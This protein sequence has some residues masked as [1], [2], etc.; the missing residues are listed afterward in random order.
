MNTTEAHERLHNDMNSALSEIVFAL[1]KA[2]LSPCDALRIANKA[3]NRC[4]II[5]DDIMSLY[6]LRPLSEYH[7]DF[8]SVL[9]WSLPICEPPWVGVPDCSSW[10]GY[11]THWSPLPDCNRMVANDGTKVEL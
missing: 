10:P 9:W 2:G 11:H 3:T 1:E 7:E 4:W 8:D 6:E 5:W